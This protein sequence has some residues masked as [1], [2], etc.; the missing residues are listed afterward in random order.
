MDVS[1]VT[2]V[3]GLIALAAVLPLA[4]WV[5]A[6]A[7]AR[8]VRA[9][10]A[11]REPPARAHVPVVVALVAVPALLALAAAQPVLE[12]TRTRYARSD[13]E[14][15]FVFDTSRSMLAAPSPRARNRFTRARAAG[16]RLRARLGDVPVGVASMTDHTLPHL[17]PTVDAAV[18]TAAVERALAIERPPPVEGFNVRVTTLSAL[19][20]VARG[21]FFSPSAKRRLLV[22]FT[23][24]ET[25][26]FARASIERVFN[27]PPPIKTVIVR[28]GRPGERVFA[29]NGVPEPA[30]EPDPRAPE[31]AVELAR[32]TGG[33]AF[34]EDEVGAA[35]RAARAVLG[36]GEKVKQGEERRATA[37]APYAAMGAFVPLAFLLR[38]RNSYNAW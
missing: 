11:L 26:P 25:Q 23:D 4:A 32:A 33:E 19:S 18:F 20:D 9:S 14:T 27:R 16:V 38:R 10:L 15:F 7:R 30:Y 28:F 12:L 36:E 5:T 22:V 31:T 6:Q 24:A 29:P 2:P 35:A 34:S 37:L 8:R 13:A 1:F 21:N 3:A 17:F